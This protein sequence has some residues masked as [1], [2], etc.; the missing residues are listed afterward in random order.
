MLIVSNLSI[1]QHF[2]KYSNKLTL[3]FDENYIHLT[4]LLMPVQG[5]YERNAAS[6][7][8]RDMKKAKF[9]NCIRYM[10]TIKLKSEGK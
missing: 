8:T 4:D 5:T 2:S 3:R 7:Y 10:M 9:H 1:A 6:M